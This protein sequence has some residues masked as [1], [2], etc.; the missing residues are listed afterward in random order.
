MRE[1]RRTDG[2]TRNLKQLSKKHGDLE[3]SVSDAL[4]NIATAG[5]ADNDHLIR[6]LGG[7]PVYKRRMGLGK[8]GKRGGARLIFYCDE[9][10]LIALFAYAK[11]KKEDI[12]SAEIADALGR[13]GLLP[14]D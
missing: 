7:Q 4:A 6:G 8:K 12:L 10:S 14:Q 13:A 3:T 9:E 1:I 2:S 11:N 5:P